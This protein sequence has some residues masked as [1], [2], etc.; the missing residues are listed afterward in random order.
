[1]QWTP[2]VSNASIA[3][4]QRQPSVEAIR[5]TTQPAAAQVTSAPS[6]PT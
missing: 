1:M 4:K 5:A 6:G 3:S 2:K